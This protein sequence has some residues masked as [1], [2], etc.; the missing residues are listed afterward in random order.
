MTHKICFIGGDG[1]G[2][3]VVAHARRVLDALGVSY[4]GTEARAGYACYQECGSAL[5]AETI[6]AARA[7]DSVL[8][9]AVTTPPNIPNYSSAIVGLRRAL[10]LYANVRPC[11]SYPNVPCLRQDIDLVIVRE[12]TEGMYSGRERREDGGNTA[13]SERVITRR[14]SERILRFAYEYAVRNGRK[15]VTF[16]HKANIL[17]ETCGLFREVALEVAARYPQIQTE[18]AIVDAMAMR[19]IKQPQDFGVIV[20]T[21]LFGDILSDEAAQLVGGLGMTPSGSY[22]EKNALFEPTHGSAPKY[23]GKDYVNPCATLLSLRMLL[24]HLGE[25]AAAERLEAAVGS[26]L[27]EGKV[28]TADIG[29]NAKTSEMTDAIIRKIG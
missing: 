3:E 12:N 25:R 11:R 15:K 27:A 26:V 14:G 13:I 1:V 5:P 7:S 17:R 9:G 23:A 20:T 22:G 2:P 8:F 18:E 4:S 29:G 24:E 6:E 28:L 16:V 10:D 19:L 21:N